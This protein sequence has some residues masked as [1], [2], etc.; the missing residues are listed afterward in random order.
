MNTGQTPS[1]RGRRTRIDANGYA[2]RLDTAQ[3]FLVS[4]I[5]QAQRVTLTRCGLTG[6]FSV[7]SSAAEV[8]FAEERP[9]V[10]GR[11]QPDSESAQPMEVLQHGRLV[12][13][14][15]ALLLNERAKATH[16]TK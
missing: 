13:R 16:R 2:G 14:L 10:Q 3:R 1:V 4:A 9:T 8:R 7:R 5:G 6:C 15:E 12:A 11:E